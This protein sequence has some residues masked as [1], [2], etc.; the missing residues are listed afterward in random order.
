MP[1]K[2]SIITAAFNAQDTI[3]HTLDSVL[4]QECVEYEHI[5]IEA[6][7]SDNTLKIIES[8]RTAY[9]NKGIALRVYSQKDLGIY[10]GMNKGL[11]YA[12]GDIV[13]FLNADDFYSHS[14]VLDFII[15]AF[16]KPDNIKICYANILYVDKDLK[17]LRILK[18]KAF[19][20][21]G[22]KLGAHPPHPSFYVKRHI[23]EQY[24]GFNLQYSIAAD[25]EIML[26]LLYKHR[27]KSFY[28]DET[29]VKMRTGGKSNASVWNI[30]HAN[31]ECAQ[32]WRALHLSS[33]PLFLIFKP[34]RKIIHTISMFISQA[35]K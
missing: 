23:Y 6:Q 24:G 20:P 18:G 3:A 1:P 2:I 32:A 26:R 21:F 8:Y 4:M 7:S 9:E 33:I 14:L 13:G 5:I 16:A 31:I 35:I 29:I 22:F 19:S 25:Y 15:W 28:F 34:L 27:I 11:Q 30:L 10:D 17:P 12:C